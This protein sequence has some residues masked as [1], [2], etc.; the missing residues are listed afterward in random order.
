MESK[1]LFTDE[2]KARYQQDGFLVVPGALSEQTMKE[3]AGEATRVAGAEGDGCDA[4]YYYEDSAREPG[5]RIVRRIERLSRVSPMV[6][7]LFR[8]EALC[9]RVSELFGEPAVLFKDKLNFKLPGGSG[10]RAHVDGHFRWKDDQGRERKGWLEHGSWFINVLICID[11]S[12]RDNG[13]L[14]V[15]PLPQTL[16]MLG[17]GFDD[18]LSSVDGRG[19]DVTPEHEAKAALELVET[20]PGDLVFFDWRCIHRSRP[21]NSD[22]PRRI[23]YA[24]YNRL[25]E[26][27]QMDAYYQGKRASLEPVAR[28]SLR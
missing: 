5:H 14:E 9:G 23:L 16:D 8:S 12:N 24:T 15:A 22:C 7:E 17:R 10:Y 2:H 21:N 20:R 18:I 25:S 1:P 26:G 11:A 27:D 4:S 3:L 13:C 6:D 28:K 19:P